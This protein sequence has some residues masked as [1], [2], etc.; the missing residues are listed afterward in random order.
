MDMTRPVT[1]TINFRLVDIH[2]DV[3]IS[4][5]DG[6]FKCGWFR[7]IE[8]SHSKKGLDFCIPLEHPDYSYVVESKLEKISEGDTINMK[9]KSVN[10]RNTLWICFDIIS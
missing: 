1:S 3:R 9:L 4:G 8:D 5:E 7:I 2:S 6:P 10:E